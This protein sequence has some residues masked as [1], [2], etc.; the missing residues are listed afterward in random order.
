MCKCKD[1]TLIGTAYN[2]NPPMELYKC[3]QCNKET[4]SIS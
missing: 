1:K 4:I 2:M 3:N